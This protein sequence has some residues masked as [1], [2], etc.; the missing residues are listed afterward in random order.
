MN[1]QQHS[2][3]KTQLIAEKKAAEKKGNMQEYEG[4]KRALS[5][6]QCLKESGNLTE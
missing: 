6:L 1:K 4:C 2:Q 3:L 5:T